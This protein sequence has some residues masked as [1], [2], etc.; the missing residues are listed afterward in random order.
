MK[1]KG[2]NFSP[3]ISGDNVSVGNK[4]LYLQVMS[5]EGVQLIDKLDPICLSN[6]FY[7]LIQDVMTKESGGGF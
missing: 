3:V 6:F 5:F 4:N 7:F 2:L 1:N